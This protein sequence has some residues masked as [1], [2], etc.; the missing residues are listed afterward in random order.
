MNYMDEID[1]QILEILDKNCRTS[2]DEIGKQLKGHKLT[3]NA[4]RTR[5]VRL[6]EEGVIDSFVFKINPEI[7]D[8]K[9]CY[10]KFTCPKKFQ[11][12]EQLHAVLGDDPRYSEIMTSLDGITIV[13]VAG[14]NEKKLKQAIN[15]IEKL[16]KDYK[17]DLIIHRY[18]PPIEK[19]E[20]SNTLLKVMNSLIKDVRKSVAEIAKE[21][22]ITSKSV[23]FYLNQIMQKNIG[24]FSINIQPN[25]ISERIFLSVF[26]S[27]PNMDHMNFMNLLDFISRNLD[28]IIIKN[29]LLIDPPGIF[30]NLTTESLEEIDKIE[31]KVREF[32]GDGYIFW[33]MFPS[34]TIYRDNLP[35]K[36]VRERVKKMEE[37]IKKYD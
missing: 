7:F 17:L 1:L 4:V 29:Y 11:C 15:K 12:A 8:L 18:K 37:E 23:R 20:L 31:F 13:N 22:R 28:T 2:Y 32:L 35:N 19:V 16:V 9:T 21:C 33:K 3:G 27:K 34:L 5:V 10:L 26:V 36:I 30:I 6:I 25:K 24:R 14:E